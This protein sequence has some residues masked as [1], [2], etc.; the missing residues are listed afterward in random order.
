MMDTRRD[1][2]KL[3][4]AGLAGAGL[5]ACGTGF[6]ADVRKPA[7]VLVH[8]AWH[9]A[10]AWQKVIPELARQ[11]YAALAIDLPGHGLNARFPSSYFERPLNPA[12][13]GTEVSAVAAVTVDQCADAVVAAVEQLRAGGCEKVVVVAH[14]AGGV[15]VTQAVERIPTQVAAVVYLSAFMLANGQTALEA[16]SLP[17]GAAAQVPLLLRANPATV[18]ALRIDSASTESAYLDQIKSAFYGDITDAALPAIRNM[19]TPDSPIALGVTPTVKTAAGWGS[20]RRYY[21]K[22]SQ[23]QAIPPALQQKFIDVADAGSGNKTIVQSI[24]ASH[25]PFLSVPNEL[26]AILSS[27]AGS[28]A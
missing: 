11:G 27:I 17:E 19:L 7:F 22:C 23:D 12:N 6:T 21:I 8:G 16:T 9:G 2:I 28:I 26:S 20:V 3:A 15:A 14:S 4:S 1:L 10:W 25:S 24:N 18:A 13:F 5:A